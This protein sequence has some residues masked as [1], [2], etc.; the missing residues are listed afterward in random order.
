M[1]K[2]LLKSQHQNCLVVDQDF[3]D[4][5][6]P[7]KVCVRDGVPVDFGKKITGPCS[8]IGEWPGFMRI[9]P[10][11]AEKIAKR[12]EEYIARPPVTETYEEAIR[13]VLTT[14]PSGTFD[15]MD[16]TGIPWIEIDFPEDLTRAKEVILPR[17]ENFDDSGWE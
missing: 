14:E 4:G 6:E 2:N 11:V 12:A 1:G 17:I 10:T 15:Y 16:V 3:E 5:E 13:D 7:V 9:S 8:I